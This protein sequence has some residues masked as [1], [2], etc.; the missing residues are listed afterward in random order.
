MKDIDIPNAM[1]LPIGFG[2][3]LMIYG[4][5]RGP[6]GTLLVGVMIE[7][8]ALVAIWEINFRRKT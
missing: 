2:I 3:G 8:V 6:P 4:F 7:I 1:F 5:I